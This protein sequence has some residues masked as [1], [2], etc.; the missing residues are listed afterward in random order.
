MRPY[1][2]A[3]RLRDNLRMEQGRPDV[4]GG[5]LPT[6]QK[7]RTNVHSVLS[8]VLE[9][10]TQLRICLLSDDRARRNGGDWRQGGADGG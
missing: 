10:Q 7:D 8:T 4:E 9:P 3:M 1:G 5:S 6:V 2:P